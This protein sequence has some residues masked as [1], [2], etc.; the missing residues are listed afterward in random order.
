[1]PERNAGKETHPCDAKEEEEEMKTL[2]KVG[3]LVAS[4]CL[5]LPA[6]LN[7][8]EKKEPAGEKLFQQHCAACHPGGGNIIKPAMTLHKKDL[9]AHGVKTAKDIV[10]KMR[11][12]G[13]GMTRFDAK[14]V[15]DK[16][17]QEI[18]EYIL[19]TFK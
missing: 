16:D 15:S 14:T 13:P 1:M 11:N 5:V 8:A 17:A 9:D 19:K 12:P 2:A 3:V 18:A 10:G 7:A 4:M 6:V